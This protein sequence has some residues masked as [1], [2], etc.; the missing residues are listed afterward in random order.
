MSRYGY[1]EGE[2]CGRGGCNGVIELPEV[3]GCTCFQ[4]APCDA[5]TSNYF[6]CP[7]CGWV[8][9]KYEKGEEMEGKAKFYRGDLVVRRTD[10]ID[11]ATGNKKESIQEVT[12]KVVHV[13]DTAD[14]FIYGVG[15]NIPGSVSRFEE[16]EGYLYPVDEAKTEALKWL[17]AR[18]SK[19]LYI[20]G[21]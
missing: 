6:T 15:T 5:C 20:P 1:E 16:K 19:V 8:Y 9:D 17:M 2:V 7:V 14:G 18:I 12:Y 11:I 3:E 10:V 4:S 13:K 21:C